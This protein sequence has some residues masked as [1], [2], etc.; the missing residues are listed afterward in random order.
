MVCYLSGVLSHYLCDAM[1]SYHLRSTQFTS[2]V[3][4]SNFLSRN[5][6]SYSLILLTIKGIF[7]L[8]FGFGF[9]KAKS[10]I[11]GIDLGISFF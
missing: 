6:E 4:L 2:V 11:K 10:Q 8:A 1:I 9:C 5:V 3:L 7:G